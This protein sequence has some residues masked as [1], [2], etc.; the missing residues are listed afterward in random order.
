L[1]L[2]DFDREIFIATTVQSTRSE[3][4]RERERERKETKLRDG[5]SVAKKDD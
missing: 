2:S 3:N 4:R 1:S 5:M